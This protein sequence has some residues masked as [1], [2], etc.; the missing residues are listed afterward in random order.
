MKVKFEETGFR[1]PVEHSE[2]LGTVFQARIVKEALSSQTQI[3]N[4]Y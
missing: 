1:T 3:R 2:K 4:P